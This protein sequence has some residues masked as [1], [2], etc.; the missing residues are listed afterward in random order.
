MSKYDCEC[1]LSSLLAKT[2]QELFTFSVSLRPSV[3]SLQ[4][5]SSVTFTGGLQLVFIPMSTKVSSFNK[6]QKIGILWFSAYLHSA[7][8]ECKHRS[9]VD[10]KTRNADP[11]Y[12]I[13]V[14]SRDL[15]MSANESN[16]EYSNYKGVMLCNRPA[17]SEIQGTIAPIL[18]ILLSRHDCNFLVLRLKFFVLRQESCDQEVIQM[19]VLSPVE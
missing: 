3:F 13:L 15:T 19:Q 8:N 18:M 10:I 16:R 11:S 4:S 7:K 6:W 9:Q 17:I 12:A 2:F 5:Q 14:T 1:P